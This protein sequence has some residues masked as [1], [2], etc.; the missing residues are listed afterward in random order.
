MSPDPKAS[1][2]AAGRPPTRLALVTGASSGIGAAYARRLA[3][4]GWDLVLVAR[5]RDALEALAKEL[6]ERH[7]VEVEV[8]PAD[9]TRDDERRAVEARL[10]AE[11]PVDLLV[12]NAGFGT[13]GDFSASAVDAEEGQIQLNVLALLRLTHAALPGM[14]Q[15][16]NGGV[17]NVSSLAGSGPYP[18]MATYAATKAFV[19]SF[20]EA[21][22]EE[23]RGS[24]VRVLVVQPGFVRTEFQERAGV[25]SSDI[26]EPAWLSPETVVDASLEALSKDEVVSVPGLGYRVLAGAS[27]LLPRAALRRV[28]GTL[29]KSRYRRG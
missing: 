8:L 7:A 3:S 14:L 21:L 2:H 5:R 6:G 9:L 24:G 10:G 28:A 29:L 17:L 12:N 19:N 27:A 20:S 23:L 22:A 16:R 13:V 11:P 4:D 18:M 26:P 15:R 1:P 25:D